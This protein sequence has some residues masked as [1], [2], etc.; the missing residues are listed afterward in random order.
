MF[1]I[2]YYFI[3]LNTISADKNNKNRNEQSV[4]LAK[5]DCWKTFF[6]YGIHVQFTEQRKAKRS[7][8]LYEII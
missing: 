3:K 8:L 7:A 4:R 2:L 5:F 1:F 6:E